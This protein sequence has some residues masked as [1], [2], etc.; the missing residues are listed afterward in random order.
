MWLSGS[1]S[2][3]Y[4]FGECVK[5]TV[6][7]LGGSIAQHMLYTCRTD[8]LA[9]GQRC[10]AG[11]CRYLPLGRR[12]WGSCHPKG[13]CGVDLG[14][15]YLKIICLLACVK[16]L[17]LPGRLC[18]A[19]L[20]KYKRFLE[21]LRFPVFVSILLPP[22]P[23]PMAGSL[24]R[25]RGWWARAASAFASIHSSCLQPRACVSVLF[26]WGKTSVVV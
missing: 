18:Q 2:F 22:I 12:I 26:H 15:K 19:F 6:V 21:S 16:M 4:Q 13:I 9:P 14:R 10:G 20:R 1:W 3:K 5:Q 23:V 25:F 8:L 17:I 7:V 11:G 24:S